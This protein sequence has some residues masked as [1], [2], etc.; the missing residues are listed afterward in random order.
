MILCSEMPTPTEEPT[1]TTIEYV[2]TETGE[3][4]NLLKSIGRLSNESSIE[5]FM[6]DRGKISKL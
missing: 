4:G 3:C 5:C 1:T 2:P 6:N